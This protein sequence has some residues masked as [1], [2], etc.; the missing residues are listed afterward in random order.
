MVPGINDPAHLC[1]IAGLIPGPVQWVKD[2]V[3]PQL[4]HLWQMGL[5]FNPWPR[6]FHMPRVPMEE[7]EEKEKNVLLLE[8]TFKGWGGDR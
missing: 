4:Q 5:G 6:N 3:L 7:K 8:C 1:G 2:L